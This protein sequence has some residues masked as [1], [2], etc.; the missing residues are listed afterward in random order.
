M[1]TSAIVYACW[2]YYRNDQIQSHIT[3]ETGQ[4]SWHSSSSIFF[5]ILFVSQGN[6][7]KN[8]NFTSG[9]IWERLYIWEMQIKMG[10]INCK[11]YHLKPAIFGISWLATLDTTIFD[12]IQTGRISLTTSYQM[13]HRVSFDDSFWNPI[14]I[15]RIFY[16][17]VLLQ[18]FSQIFF[19]ALLK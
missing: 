14:N 17:H 2:S 10:K 16:K 6:K 1:I 9:N 15:L 4:D 12:L 7:V 3:F 18:L 19:V 11:I 8:V 13:F 5:W